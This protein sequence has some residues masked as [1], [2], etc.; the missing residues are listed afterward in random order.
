MT[1]VEWLAEKYNYITWMRNRDE[2]SAGTADKWRAKFLQEAID[3]EKQQMFE[4]VK[5]CYV[6]GENSLKFH[7]EE[8]EK[9]YNKTFCNRVQ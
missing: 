8:F 2:I 5:Y 3:M 7:Q 6:N 1:A 4:Y 9:Y